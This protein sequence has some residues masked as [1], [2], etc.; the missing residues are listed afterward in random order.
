VPRFFD[1]RLAALNLGTAGGASCAGSLRGALADALVG[2]E[3]FD[4]VIDGR[5]QGGYITRHYGRPETGVHAFQMELSQ[6]TYMEEDPPYAFL[7][8][9][10]AKL[11]PVLRRMLEAA[12]Q[13]AVTP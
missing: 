9:R 12:V 7:A 4:V 3:G 6:A 11:R 5:F 8:D 1:G 10:A 13:W 2:N